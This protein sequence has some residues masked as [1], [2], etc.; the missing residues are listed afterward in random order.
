[1]IKAIDLAQESSPSQAVS[2]PVAKI[3]SPPALTK[4]QIIQSLRQKSIGPVRGQPVVGAGGY[5]P[6]RPPADGTVAKP[7]TRFGPKPLRP[8]SHQE[9]K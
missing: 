4:Q 1:M 5:K 7:F 6:F 8:L 2:K 9:R 3:K